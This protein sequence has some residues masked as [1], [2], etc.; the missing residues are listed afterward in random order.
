MFGPEL[1]DHSTTLRSLPFTRP[2]AARG[3]H[4][5]PGIRTSRGSDKQND[6][7]H[8]TGPLTES[9]FGPPGLVGYKGSHDLAY[10][11]GW[12]GN[13][14]A[15]SWFGRRRS[16]GGVRGCATGCGTF[17]R[18]GQPRRGNGAREFTGLPD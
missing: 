14:N 10:A 8:G 1:L 18:G 12:R 5:G 16:A 13:L 4:I 2:G 11:E 15:S 17:R 9:G 6:L 7:S 3:R